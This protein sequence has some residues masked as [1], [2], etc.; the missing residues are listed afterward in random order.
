MHDL[1]GDEF[2]KLVDISSD[3]NQAWFRT[4][5]DRVATLNQAGLSRFINQLDLNVN[6]QVFVTQLV[7]RLQIF[8]GIRRND[9]SLW[10]ALAMLLVYIVLDMGEGTADRAFIEGLLDK[11]Y[12]GWRAAAGGAG[13]GIVR[14][15]GG[16]AGGGG[17]GGNG[18]YP[19]SEVRILVLAANPLNTTRLDLEHEITRLRDELRMSTFRDRFRFTAEVAVEIDEI[20]RHLM[21]VKPH[22]IHFAGHGDGGQII[23][24]DRAGQA[25]PARPEGLAAMFELVDA[26]RIVVLNA[27]YSK[28]QAERL[29]GFVDYVVGMETQIRD[30]SALQF[31]IGFYR[32]LANGESLDRAFKWA[33][34]QVMNVTPDGNI[35]QFAAKPGFDAAN[36]VLV[37]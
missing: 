32:A 5:N 25:Q 11:L 31:T 8:G 21:T 22:I 14:G 33:R 34:A 17:Q 15:D 2:R 28:P 26:L 24:R 1:N 27:C 18:R 6:T 4:I 19:L 16:G 9:G 30:D 29:S 35:P 23:F 36:T 12:P 20:S 7:S 37:R 13:G 3:P 10:P